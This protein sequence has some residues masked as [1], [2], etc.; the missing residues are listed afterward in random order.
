MLGRLVVLLALGASACNSKPETKASASAAAPSAVAPGET[1]R[2]VA[3][4]MKPD[5]PPSFTLS[6][7]SEK[8]L[9][10][11][12]TH[13]GWKVTVM[14]KTAPDAKTS[15][16]RVS[17]VKM[18]KD[19]SLESF[20]VVRCGGEGVEHKPGTAYFVAGECDIEVEVRRGIR[21]KTEESKKLLGA[22]LQASL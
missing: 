8:D 4:E 22:V 19:G 13:A 17:S 9:S 10:S 5:K 6:K 11:L 18:E 20:T 1:D 14:G 21:A 15:R 16:V 7:L 2:L 3:V 12:V